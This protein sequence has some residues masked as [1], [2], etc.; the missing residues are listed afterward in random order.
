MD[1]A[2]LD[3]SPPYPTVVSLLPQLSN[4]VFTSD[5]RRS[6]VKHA[7][8]RASLFADLT[9]LTFILQHP[10]SKDLVDLT[11]QDE[12]GLNIIS[13][14]IVCFGEESDRSVDREECIRLLILHGAAIDTPDNSMGSAHYPPISLS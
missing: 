9:L 2:E 12:D 14:S 4:K 7:L 10:L 3:L 11:A 8:G 13:Q 1:W 6:L 5:Q